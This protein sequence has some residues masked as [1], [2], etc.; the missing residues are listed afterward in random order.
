M[1]PGH[2]LD[3]K[4]GTEQDST[5][6]CP[7]LQPR[8]RFFCPGGDRDLFGISGSTQRGAPEGLPVLTLTL[9]E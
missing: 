7:S 2:F 3:A 1:A 8:V 5:S 4:G 9:W 6:F